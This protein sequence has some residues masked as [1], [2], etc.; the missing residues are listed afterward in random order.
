MKTHV[1]SSGCVDV[2]FRSDVCAS[3]LSIG[4]HSQLLLLCWPAIVLRQRCCWQ[5]RLDGR[6]SRR[7]AI[8]FAAEGYN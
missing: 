1:L 6:E 7:A 2:P 8:G 4:C 3:L 5:L